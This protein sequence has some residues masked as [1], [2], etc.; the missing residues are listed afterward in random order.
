MAAPS[1][2]WLASMTYC[3]MIWLASGADAQSGGYYSD[4]QLTEP[5]AAAQDRAAARQLWTALEQQTTLPM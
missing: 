5:S 1:G 3:A 4:K 2:A